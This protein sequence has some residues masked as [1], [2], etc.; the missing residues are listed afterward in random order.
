MKTVKKYESIVISDTTAGCMTHEDCVKNLYDLAGKRL[1]S[2][3][4]LG[5]PAVT[6][7]KGYKIPLNYKVCRE[8]VIRNRGERLRNGT[9]K[10]RNRIMDAV[11]FIRPGDRA[12]CQNWDFTVGFEVKANIRDLNRDGKMSAYLNWTDLF[13][14]A[15]P[16][17]LVREAERKVADS[18]RIGVVSIDNGLVVKM[19]KW[20]VVPMDKRHELMKEAFFRHG[21]DMYENTFWL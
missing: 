19:P 8:V 16:D 6:F 2:A 3:L 1:A 15:V 18:E 5:T 17:H 7:A 11:M 12:L 13:F 14:L 9:L 21:G 10:R 4:C 20:Q